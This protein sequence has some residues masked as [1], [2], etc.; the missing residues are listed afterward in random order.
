[1]A[2]SANTVRDRGD[3]GLNPGSVPSSRVQPALFSTG[4]APRPSRVVA[5]DAALAAKEGRHITHGNGG[6]QENWVCPTFYT[7]R[8]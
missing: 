1:M 4:A 2:W 7:W 6:N 3:D 8:F 5:L